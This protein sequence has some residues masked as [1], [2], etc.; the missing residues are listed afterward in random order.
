[1]TPTHE[2]LRTTA[3]RPWPL[4][5]GPWRFYQ[6]WNRALFLHW[7]VDLRELRPL[8]PP[9]LEIDLFDGAPWVSLVSFTMERM[10]PRRWPSF[11][12]LSDFHEINIRTYVRSEGRAGVHFL[13]IEGGKRASCWIARAVSRL[14]YRHSRII[15]TGGADEARNGFHG[16]ALRIWYRTGSPM[17]NKSS[18]DR[19]LTERYALFQDAPGAINGFEIH[20]LEWPTLEVRL[21]E[22]E[23][24]YP[25]FGSL[26]DGAPHRSHYSP[27]V[28][29]VAWGRR[30][31]PRMLQGA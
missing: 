23:L 28:Q 18:L 12:P 4:P 15:R 26:L 22:V 30:S 13:S 14:P 9:E 2:L 21:D 31:R 11:P 17:A 19:W 1:M 25:R 29:V 6:E 3:H 27:G 24:C 16:D 20:H 5:P 7:A 10:R 8:V